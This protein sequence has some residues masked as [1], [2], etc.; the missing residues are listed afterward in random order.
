MVFHHYDDIWLNFLLHWLY[1]AH[2]FHSSQPEPLLPPSEAIPSGPVP[3][4]L[5]AALVQHCVEDGH[6]VQQNDVKWLGRVRAASTLLAFIIILF[7]QCYQSIRLHFFP[8]Q[9]ARFF[10]P[11]YTL[12]CRPTVPSS[13][14]HDPWDPSCWL[15]VQTFKTIL[16][17]HCRSDSRFRSA[18]DVL[19]LTRCHCGQR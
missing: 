1:P 15:S 8:P 6:T 12:R 9:E 16:Q 7:R 19:D 17:I 13:T 18:A 11:F 10:F 5:S 3:A 2:W 4:A 14:H